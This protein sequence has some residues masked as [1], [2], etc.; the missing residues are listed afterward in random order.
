MAS[1]EPSLEPSWMSDTLAAVLRDHPEISDVAVRLETNACLRLEA[2]FR[3]PMAQRLVAKGGTEDG[4]LPQ[5]TLWLDFRGPMLGHSAPEVSLRPDFPTHLAHIQPWKGSEDRVVPCFLDG[6]PNELLHARG[7]GAVLDQIICWLDDA[8]NG[9]LIDPQQGWEPTRRDGVLD[10]FIA[11]EDWIRGLATPK[12]GSSL[13]KLFYAGFDEPDFSF[14]RATVVEKRAP[15]TPATLGE[16]HCIERGDIY[17]GKGLCLVVW[18]NARAGAA[19]IYSPEWVRSFGDL[20][21]RADEFGCLKELETAIE[22]LERLRGKFQPEYRDQSDP[23]IQLAIVLIARRPYH[24]I[25]SPSS[26]EIMPYATSIGYGSLAPFSDVQPVRPLSHRQIVSR[27]LL[28]K[29]SGQERDAPRPDWTLVGAGSLGSKLGLHLARSG[30]GPKSVIDNRSLSPHHMARHALLPKS[31]HPSQ[32]FEGGKASALASAVRA[33][34]Q[35]CDPIEKDV[36]V[37]TTEK[38]TPWRRRDVALVNTTAS[39]AVRHALCRMDRSDRPRLIEA[40]LFSNGRIGVLAA[41]AGKGNSLVSD[42]FETLRLHASKDPT[43]MAH[44]FEGGDGLERISIGQGCGSVT[45]TV[46]DASLSYMAAAMAEDLTQ[47]IKVAAETDEALIV[48]DRIDPAAGLRRQRLIVKPAITLTLDTLPDWSI[49]LQADTA[50]EI[51]EEILRWPGKETG[52]VLIGRRC[53]FTRQIHVVRALIAPPDSVRA[54]GRFE[55]GVEGRQAGIATAVSALG[56]GYDAIGTWHN[57]PNDTP[58]S[59][60]DLTLAE[61]LARDTGVPPVC[62]IRT[63]R[64]WRVF[65]APVDEDIV[66]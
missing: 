64:T 36:R 31:E 14:V 8:A 16:L 23:R 37:L 65:S 26:L 1:T 22:R 29:L 57:H 50:S 10:D 32:F 45:M 52:G 17:R 34:S 5:E 9:R 55:L 38:D 24:L 59:Q 56:G 6:D 2:T 41:E 40:A 46:D 49:R 3:V 11:D 47:L 44:L 21:H 35:T 20:K 51:D 63:P 48:Y 19:A 15:F 53:N 12:A 25:G 39:I 61:G 60:T 30:D 58:A 18:G 62:L 43:L 7:L 27:P 28:L 13:F 33:L 54:P 42:L 66:P 4:V